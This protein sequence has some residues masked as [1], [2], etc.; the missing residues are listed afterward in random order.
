VW[1]MPLFSFPGKWNIESG[2][3]DGV[4]AQGWQA[5]AGLS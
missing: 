1:H 3:E 4:V 2:P 5:S